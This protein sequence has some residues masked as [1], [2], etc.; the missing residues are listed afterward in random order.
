MNQEIKSLTSIRGIAAF[1][2]MIFH[3]FYLEVYPEMSVSRIAIQTV[4]NYGFLSVDLFFFLSAFVMSLAYAKVFEHGVSLTSYKR[5]MFKRFAR[6]YPL[7]FIF[8]FVYYFVNES[9][10]KSLFASL[11]MLQI[12]FDRDF[13]VANVLWSLSA[14]WVLYLVFPFVFYVLNKIKFSKVF[15]LLILLCSVLLFYLKD[16]NYRVLT[17]QGIVDLGYTTFDMSRGFVAVFRCFLGYLIGISL[18]KYLSTTNTERLRDL[19]NPMYISP[20]LI[21]LFFPNSHF[22]IFCFFVLLIASCFLNDSKYSIINKPLIYKLGL[23]SYSI[24]ILHKA[25]K[26]V[27][28]SVIVIEQ[29]HFIILNLL[30]IF[31]TILLSAIT[32]KWIEKY[33]NR[34]ILGIL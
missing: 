18:Y 20:L 12:F 8:C 24:Y 22:F 5:F 33:F 13:Y 16:V 10:Y 26:S 19:L 9:T 3:Y 21:A 23:W 31:M 7:Y 14:E 29:N 17:S 27:L 1:Y 34:K 32:F 15:V 6:V 2:V 25:V 28:E 11:T 4:I 30:S